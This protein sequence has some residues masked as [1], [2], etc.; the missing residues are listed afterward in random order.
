MTDRMGNE[1]KDKCNVK[2]SKNKNFDRI[3]AEF[4]K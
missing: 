1:L 2:T 4:I 3:G